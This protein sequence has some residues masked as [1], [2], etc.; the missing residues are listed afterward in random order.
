MVETRRSSSSSKRPLSSSPVTS[1]HISSKRS[2]ASELASSPANGATGSGSVK[3]SG[4]DSPVTE[5]R[6]SDL[7]VSDVFKAD[8]G[9]VPTDKSA[10]ADVENVSL[11]SPGTLG[12]AAVDAEKAE[13]LS[14]R[15]KKK[16]AKSGS[17]VP[18]G[19]LLS[20]LS[21]VCSMKFYYFSYLKETSRAE[22]ASIYAKRAVQ[23]A[24]SQ[25]KRA[26]SSVEADIT[27]ASSLH[28]L[29]KQEVST[30]TSKNYTF[31]KGD[32][33]KFV[34]TT[35][36]S[37]LSSLQPALRGPTIGV[38][39]KV[40]LAFEENGSSKIGVRFDRSIPEGNDLGGLCEEDHGFFCTAS[41]L[42]LEPGG[43]DVDK[44]VN[45]IFEVCVI[46]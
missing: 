16:P 3:E 44:P 27:G 4:S 17:K 35:S 33:V 41:S 26:T 28:V 9:S 40:V 21:Q 2:K 23:A 6:S 12:E 1:N 7:R 31:K 13:G 15:V 5:L 43:D 36:P 11:V 34:G 14:G 38:R 18:W 29:P 30:A 46:G 24:V 10:D 20:Q 37:T 25:Q 22:R 39:G 45:E 32:R 19:K 8:D 42:R